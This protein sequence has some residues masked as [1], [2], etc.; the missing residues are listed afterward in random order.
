MA[1]LI[2]A[3][4]GKILGFIF[5]VIGAYKLCS[6]YLFLNQAKR[7][8]GHLKGWTQDSEYLWK[9]IVGFSTF[10][11]REIEFTSKVGCSLKF[12]WEI[13]RPL[14]VIYD[15]A[16]PENAQIYRFLYFW[17]LPLGLL[18]LGLVFDFAPFKT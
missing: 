14:E 11:G 5:A 13:G 4:L 17:L 15:S 8:V 2:Q 9:P 12:K 6:Q 16:K 10:D 18:L 1:D 3:Y 7:T